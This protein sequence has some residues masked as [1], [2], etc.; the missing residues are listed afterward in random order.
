MS[1]S[2]QNAQITLVE[3]RPVVTPRL[4]E[5]GGGGLHI[6]ALPNSLL[7]YEAHILKSWD[8]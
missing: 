2:D 3:K 1:A 5:R 8:S 6:S 7:S 4:G